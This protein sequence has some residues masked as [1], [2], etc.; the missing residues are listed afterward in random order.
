MRLDLDRF[1]RLTGDVSDGENAFRRSGMRELRIAHGD[2]ADGVDAGLGGL[3]ELVDLHES[4]LDFDLGLLDADVF[5]AWRAS[6]GNEHLVGFDLLLLAVNGEG[7]GDAVF[8]ALDGFDF[9]VGEAVYAALAVHAHQ[10]LGDFLVFYRN[11]PGEHFEDRDVGAER[12]VD[13]GKLD[14][15]GAGANHNERLRD[16][17]EAQD[18]DVASGCGHRP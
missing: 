15:Y 16:V 9:R 10:F 7:H 18:F 12:L 17:A 5:S 3:H 11:V 4:A 8:G 2:V 13:A 1:H 14:T 6:N